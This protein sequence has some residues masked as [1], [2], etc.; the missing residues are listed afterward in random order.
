MEDSDLIFPSLISQEDL[1]ESEHE[2]WAGLWNEKIGLSLEE[3]IARKQLAW[4]STPPPVRAQY[5]KGGQ[6]SL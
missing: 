2:H 6:L 3:D 5:L 1:D 4:T